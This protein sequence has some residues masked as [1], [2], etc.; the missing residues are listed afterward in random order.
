MPTHKLNSLSLSESKFT[1]SKFI[2]KNLRYVGL[3]ACAEE[4]SLYGFCPE[5]L[6][7]LLQPIHTMPVFL[8]I[9]AI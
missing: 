4:S 6:V 7:C 8:F 3:E 5:F 1:L 9:N 2:V